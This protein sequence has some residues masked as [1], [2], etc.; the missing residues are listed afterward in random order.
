MIPVHDPFTTSLVENHK[1]ESS[2]NTP[3][4]VFSYLDHPVERPDHLRS[5]QSNLR[6]PI[7]NLLNS[8][9]I[10]AFSRN[11]DLLRTTLSRPLNTTFRSTSTA[12]LLLLLLLSL[13]SSLLRSLLGGLLLLL[14][15]VSLRATEH[16][17]PF[18][19][20]LGINT[21]EQVSGLADLVTS[22]QRSRLPA[23]LDL[24]HRGDVQEGCIQLLQNRLGGCGHVRREHAGQ[25]VDQV[26][27]CANDGGSTLGLVRN[28]RIVE[29]VRLDQSVTRLGDAHG[30]LHTGAEVRTFQI[31][32]VLA[33]VFG[34]FLQEWV[35]GLW[36]GEFRND[37]AVRGGD[38]LD[39]TV[40]EVTELGEELAVVAVHEG[41][42]LEL[43]VA[44]LWAVLQKEVTPHVGGNTGFTG[45]RAEHTHTARLAELAAFVVEVFG[46]AQVVQHG[47]LIS[48][49]DL[50]TGEDHTVE[51]HV[52]LAQELPQ[53]HIL[54][55]APPLL[56]LVCVVGSDRGVADASLEPH[57]ENLV[58]VSLQRDGNT[59]LQVSGDTTVLQ[60]LLQPGLG[61]NAGVPGPVT[62]LNSGVSPF[63]DLRLE[64]VEQDV[65]V[66]RLAADGGSAVKLAAGVD[67]IK[68][69]KEVTALVTLVST[70]IVVVAAGAFTLH[71]A[72]SQERSVLLAEGLFGGAL[73]EEAVLVQALEDRLG[74]LGVLLCRGATEVIEADVEPFVDILVDLVVF[75][76]Q[77]LRRYL[78]LQRLGFGCGSVFI[79]TTDVQR[80]ST[81]GLVVSIE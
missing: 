72:I 39:N 2:Y 55:V 56:P 75:G 31:F 77:I 59:P 11:G 4:D 54:R 13:S 78:L 71:E 32:V 38:E 23:G 9:V 16:L 7:S 81:T 21:C 20:L 33:Q 6:H 45:V 22:L 24:F 80:A 52:V 3:L 29:S 8:L 14:L 65:D 57:V 1:K 63:L 64:L 18:I 66:F 67:E 51:G 61:D 60:A 49:T 62:L 10:L 74:D 47:P 35:E 34:D 41:T 70:G 43:S 37:G 73:S 25:Q 50:S 69:I 30:C 12:L 15:P 58:L 19:R 42:P 53:L 28:Q 36:H 79:C 5:R 68:G 27:D 46:R 44:G 48:S 26:E 76:A 17:T 40:D